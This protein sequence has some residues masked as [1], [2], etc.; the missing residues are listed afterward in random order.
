[1]KRNMRK[2]FSMIEMLFVMVIM[3]GLAAIA[4]PAMSDSDESTKLASMKEDARNTI[5]F[6]NQEIVVAGNDLPTEIAGAD[7]DAVDLVNGDIFGDDKI[8]LSGNQAHIENRTDDGKNC[9]FLKIT[10]TEGV[11]DKYINYSSCYD[12]EIVVGG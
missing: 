8:V 1:M 6:V 4:I 12:T 5:N 11:S 2:G 10:D 3:A 7:G 9:Y